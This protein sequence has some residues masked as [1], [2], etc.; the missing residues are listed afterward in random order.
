MNREPWR[1]DADARLGALLIERAV[2]SKLGAISTGGQ[3]EFRE[4][5]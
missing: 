2:A 1:V 5:V 3:D 4:R